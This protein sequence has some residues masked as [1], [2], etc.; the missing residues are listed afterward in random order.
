MTVSKRPQKKPLYVFEAQTRPLTKRCG[1]AVTKR[2]CCV[3]GGRRFSWGKL[4]RARRCPM[5]SCWVR[6][7]EEG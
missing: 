2:A 6:S 7:R 5:Y 4:K 3:V 1:A